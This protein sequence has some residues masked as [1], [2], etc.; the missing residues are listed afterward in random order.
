MNG[1]RIGRVTVSDE[2]LRNSI[3]TGEAAAL[4]AGCVP[5]DVVRDWYSQTSTFLLWHPAFDVVAEGEF[6][7]EYEALFT[8]GGDSPTWQR[9]LRRE[10]NGGRC[11]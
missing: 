3:E 2:L 8:N 5:L 4:F 11:A 7:P 6:A 1:R 10:S 9:V